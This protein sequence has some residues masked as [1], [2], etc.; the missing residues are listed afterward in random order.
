M[1]TEK[2]TTRSEAAAALFGNR[3]ES[4]G[5]TPTRRNSTAGSFM[6]DVSIIGRL[7]RD[8]EVSTT[9]SGSIRCQM[10]VAVTVNTGKD[11]TATEYIKVVAFGAAA[12]AHAKYLEK[13]D[14]VHVS[15]PIRT[16]TYESPA[17]V[18]R[19]DLINHFGEA[20]T[21]ALKPDQAQKIA[22][23]FAQSLKASAPAKMSSFNIL[24]SNTTYL[25]SVGGRRRDGGAPAGNEQSQSQSNSSSDWG[26]DEV[27]F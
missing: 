20:L 17:F 4:T 7:A 9:R 5:N 12:E 22:D 25:A 10:T 3:P 8:P 18:N 26:S 23:I 15:G 1:A 14:Q 6:G 11:E 19:E 13:G 16:S 24:A 2:R 27:P 21:K